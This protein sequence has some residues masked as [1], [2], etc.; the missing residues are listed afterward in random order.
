MTD[1]LKVVF[2]CKKQRVDVV[3]WEPYSKMKRPNSYGDNMTGM[4]QFPSALKLPNSRKYKLCEWYNYIQQEII[5]RWKPLIE[6][7]FVKHV[8]KMHSASLTYCAGVS[9]INKDTTVQR[10][11]LKIPCGSVQGIFFNSPCVNHGNDCN[12]EWLCTNDKMLTN[13]W[14]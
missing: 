5:I 8:T 7:A 6:E 3:I 2:C 13:L 12:L 14:I 4:R 1:S 10:R 11:R 9:H